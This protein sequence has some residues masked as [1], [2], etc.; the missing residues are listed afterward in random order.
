MLSRHT[1]LRELPLEE[2]IRWVEDL[3]NGI[4]TDQKVLP[5][6]THEQQTELD[7]RVDAY[8][9]DCNPGRPAEAV[10]ANIRM[11]LQHARPNKQP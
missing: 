10:I 2:R 5:P 8:E 6:L 3:W 9:K 4:A 11:R 1:K 7:R